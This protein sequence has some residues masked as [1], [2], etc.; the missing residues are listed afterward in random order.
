MGLKELFDICISVFTVLLYPRPKF[1]Q[2]NIEERNSLSGE[3]ITPE[4]LN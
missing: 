2:N 3:V 1:L 4:T